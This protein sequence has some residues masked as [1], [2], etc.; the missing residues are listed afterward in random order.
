M[1]GTRYAPSRFLKKALD[2]IEI[3]GTIQSDRDFM[4]IIIRSIAPLSGYIV[5]MLFAAQFV[6]FFKYSRLG[7]ILAIHGAEFLKNIDLTGACRLCIII[8]MDQGLNRRKRSTK[9]GYLAVKW[10]GCA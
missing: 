4:K 10:L 1:H 3:V 5:L 2:F 9:T 6:H 7:I 8:R